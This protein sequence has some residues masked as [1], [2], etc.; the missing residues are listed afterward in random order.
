LR[1]AIGEGLPPRAS[2][3]LRVVAMRVVTKGH[4]ASKIKGGLWEKG[5][6][7]SKA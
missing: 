1:K 4:I 2:P 6:P 7:K 3:N 5:F